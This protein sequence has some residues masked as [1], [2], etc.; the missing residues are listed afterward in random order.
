M[1]IAAMIKMTAT[2]MSNSI[3]ENPCV[4]EFLLPV[5]RVFQFCSMISP[6]ALTVPV[7]IP[8]FHFAVI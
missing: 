8:S 5:C 3:S 2:T 6:L 7:Q 1:A 4:E